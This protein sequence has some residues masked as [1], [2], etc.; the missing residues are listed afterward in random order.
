M[1]FLPYLPVI[2]LLVAV[3]AFF[4]GSEMAIVNCDK[5]K[6][7]SEASRGVL[8][9]R[10]VEKMLQNP[11]W[12]LGTTL[13]GTNLAVV[14]NTILTTEYNPPITVGAQAGG[15]YSSTRSNR[16]T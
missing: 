4:S 2:F 5:L 16:A 1:E 3:E 6:I 11:A 10:L 9:A 13:V 12:L 8:G 15:R 14:G 7:R